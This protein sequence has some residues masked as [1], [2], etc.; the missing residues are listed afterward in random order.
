MVIVIGTA[1]AIGNAMIGKGAIATT[2]TTITI[3]VDNSLA[4]MSRA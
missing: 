1:I 3:A 2:A 4:M